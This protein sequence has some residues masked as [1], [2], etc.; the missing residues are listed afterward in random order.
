MLASAPRPAMPAHPC[1]WL[2]GLDSHCFALVALF[3]PMHRVTWWLNPDPSSKDGVCP[4]QQSWRELLVGFRQRGEWGEVGRRGN[5]RFHSF[6]K[7]KPPPGGRGDAPHAGVQR[8]SF[9]PPDTVSGAEGAVLLQVLEGN[10]FTEL[11]WPSRQK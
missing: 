4:L 1:P 2:G 8:E 9:L 3:S 6:L 7:Q 5:P 10:V 11:G